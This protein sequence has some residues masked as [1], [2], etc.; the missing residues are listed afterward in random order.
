[1][2]YILSPSILSADFK[3]LGEQMKATEENG[4][5]YLHFDVMDTMP[6]AR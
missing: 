6:L 2:D 4:A 1:M 3:V 5:T